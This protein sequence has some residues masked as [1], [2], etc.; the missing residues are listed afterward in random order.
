MEKS[1]QNEQLQQVVTVTLF[2]FKGFRAK[3]WAF[4]QMGLQP[5]KT[6]LIKGL[7]FV[8]LMGSGGAK[9]FSMIPNWG[10]YV[11]LCAWD[12]RAMADLFFS[13]SPILKSFQSQSIENQTIFLKASMVHGQWDKQNPFQ[14]NASFDP[15]NPLAVLTRA[16]IKPRF[17]W[18]FWRFVPSVS[19]AIQD[20]QGLV[21]SL[22]IGEL[23][24]IQ[25]ATFSIW[26]SGQDM[27][28]YAYKGK[29]HAEVIK[30]TRELGWYSE[31]LFARFVVLG[32]QGSGF[33]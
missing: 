30:K 20:K 4:Q 15:Q 5:F 29:H 28:K 21:F 17:W 7:Q 12:S 18:H 33:F 10:V 26:A 23:P 25:Q 22:G 9:G 19:K 1:S 13:E 2:R 8:K 3:W 27:M 31:E 16:T 14:I 11:L 6:D 24:I 32:T